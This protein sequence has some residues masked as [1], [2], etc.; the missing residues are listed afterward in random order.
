PEDIRANRASSHAFVPFYTPMAIASWRPIVDLL[1]GAGVVHT[2]GGVSTLD[3]AAFMSLV[4]KNTPW[5][6]LP[7]NT[8]YPV[9][10][11]ILITSTDVRRSNSAAMYLALASYVANGDN[12][13][14]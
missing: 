3:M 12:S 2:T 6:Y 10:K 7:G 11:S 5:K 9:N 4:D 8:A 1:T 13:V 14:D